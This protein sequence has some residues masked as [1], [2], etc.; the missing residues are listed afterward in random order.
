MGLRRLGEMRREDAPWRSTRPS[1]I[2][3]A[4]RNQ[5]GEREEDREERREY[6]EEGASQSVSHPVRQST[7]QSVSQASSRLVLRH[8]FVHLLAR[9]SVC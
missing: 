5:D 7:S 8:S 3:D 4:R 1:S 6:D 9:C 2:I